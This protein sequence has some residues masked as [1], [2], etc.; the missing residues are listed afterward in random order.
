MTSQVFEASI[1]TEVFVGPYRY[2]VGLDGEAAYDYSYLGVT[3]YRSRRIKLDPRQS[4]TET[5]QTFLHETL[6]ALGDAFEIKDW[7][8]HTTDPTTHAVTDK[9]DLMAS[10][11]LQ[12]MRANPS[13]IQWLVESR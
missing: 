5:P 11:L 4:D 1:P 13:V 9:I 10:A 12:F 2:E 7:D 6:H 3:L 8:R